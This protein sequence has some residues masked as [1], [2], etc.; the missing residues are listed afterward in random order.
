M[1]KLQR[2]ILLIVIY[3]FVVFFIEKLGSSQPN[4]ISLHS[5]IFPLALICIL[6][7]IAIG[8][9]HRSTVYL[10]VLLWVGIYFVFIF[11]AYSK[12]WISGEI[13]YYQI[14]AELSFLAIAVLLSYSLAQRLIEYEGV[15]E[16]FALPYI[17]RKVYKL[18]E[19][20]DEIKKEFIRSR[21][22]D[23]PLSI[24]T[25]EP[26]NLPLQSEGQH[27]M[28]DPQ[29]VMFDRYIYVSLA[30]LITNEARRTDLVVEQEGKNCLI[31]LC[32]ETSQQGS[33]AFG[34]RLRELAL[35]RLG[36]QITYGCAFFPEDALTF[37]D[38]LQKARFNMFEPAKLVYET[39]VSRSG[40]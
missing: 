27:R 20:M 17:G 28:P 11:F 37:D 33:V 32:P 24:I 14:I 1:T 10:S 35:E 34:E 4:I 7:I 22:H 15:F 6:S 29:K 21:R 38:L 26:A 30:Q 36:L 18:S 8:Y 25:V 39:Q 40:E 12:Q 9:L 16:N 13:N 2:P 5:F 23:R 19:A 3:L 31:L